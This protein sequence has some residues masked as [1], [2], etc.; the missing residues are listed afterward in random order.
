MPFPVDEKY[1]AE[2]EKQ[3]GV[4]FPPAFRKKMKTQNGGEIEAGG[5][6]WMMHPFLDTA[7]AKRIRRTA[8]HLVLETSNSRKWDGFP[9]N[10]ISIGDNGSG[11]KL[12]LLSDDNDQKRLNDK[13]YLWSHETGEVEELADSIDD[14]LEE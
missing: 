5:G 3:L 4:R 8:N 12:I 13:I 2:S 9:E 10:G 6:S 14:L 11:D 7:D 1:I